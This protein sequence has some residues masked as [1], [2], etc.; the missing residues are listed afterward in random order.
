[1][2]RTVVGG[3]PSWLPS[4]Q[5]GPASAFLSASGAAAPPPPVF[6]APYSISPT[7]NGI[8]PSGRGFIHLD[9]NVRGDPPH[10][11]ERGRRVSVS[12]DHN[13]AKAFPAIPPDSLPPSL[14]PTLQSPLHLQQDMIEHQF[15]TEDNTHPLH[16]ISASAVAERGHGGSL[17]TSTPF[18][19]ATAA[20]LHEEHQIHPGGPHD[21]DAISRPPFSL[22]PPAR[23][24]HTAT[25]LSRDAMTGSQGFSLQHKERERGTAS[26]SNQGF[27]DAASRD[28]KNN[29]LFVYSPLQSATTISAP[30]AEIRT[31]AALEERFGPITAPPF[32]TTNAAALPP[33][34][35]SQEMAPAEAC[36][37]R[38][39]EAP[40]SR[41]G[42]SGEAKSPTVLSAT[43]PAATCSSARTAT[44]PRPIAVIPPPPPPPRAPILLSSGRAYR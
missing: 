30:L 6:N 27:T 5:A 28:K 13:N 34:Y 33:L 15:F 22:H 9:R 17:G 39:R 35:A 24:A 1:M 25:G 21:H 3:T 4:A 44:P 14:S 18:L 16:N 20:E 26:V 37:G 41:V 29:S 36:R 40:P 19:P 2:T 38:A 32:H 8:S 43:G 31:P 23:L 7:P 42:G 10:R 12:T 11:E